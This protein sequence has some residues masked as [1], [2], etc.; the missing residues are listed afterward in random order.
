MLVPE[1]ELWSNGH[2]VFFVALAAGAITS[3]L[4]VR[5]TAGDANIFN[6][7]R[8]SKKGCQSELFIINKAI[9]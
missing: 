3:G 1:M 2:T 6:H 9:S 4:W 8:K 5:R 7:C